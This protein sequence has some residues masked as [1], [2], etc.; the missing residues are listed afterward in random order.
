MNGTWQNP[1][2]SGFQLPMKSQN[3]RNCLLI[4]QRQ[5][6]WQLGRHGLALFLLGENFAGVCLDRTSI[7]SRKSTQLTKGSKEYPRA[8]LNGN[9]LSLP[10]L[11]CLPLWHANRN[12]MVNT[13]LLKD[14]LSLVSALWSP[15]SK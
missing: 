6:F 3:H 14:F 13:K 10:G 2:V 9:G 8:Q 12:S 11:R 1:A 4:P 5:F 7:G 15:I